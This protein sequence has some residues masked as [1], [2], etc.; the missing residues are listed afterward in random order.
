MPHPI[1]KYTEAFYE[2]FEIECEFKR[3]V[4]EVI[5]NR[6][7]NLV[8]LLENYAYFALNIHPKDK[9]EFGVTKIPEHIIEQYSCQALELIM[10]YRNPYCA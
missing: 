6:D 9:Y 4:H 3:F 1:Q 8:S 7:Y 10:M 2:M 5:R